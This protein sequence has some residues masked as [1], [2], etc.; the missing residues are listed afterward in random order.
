[1][2]SCGKTRFGFTSASSGNHHD[3]VGKHRDGVGKHRDGA[4]SAGFTAEAIAW[5]VP[6]R[7]RAVTAEAASSTGEPVVVAER[8]WATLLSVAAL[9]GMPEHFLLQARRGM[10]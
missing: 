8:V 4:C 7:L 2:R 9:K 10:A 1:M 3:G 5:S 6:E